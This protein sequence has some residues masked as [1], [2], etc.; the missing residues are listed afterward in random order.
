MPELNAKE[1]AVLEVVRDAIDHGLAPSVR[2]ICARLGMKS[3]STAH[4]YLKS[5]EEKGY[6]EREGS[7][8]RAIR[9]PC[10]NVTRVPLVGT[11]TAGQPILAVESIEAY[12]PVP[13]RGDAK[14]FFALRVR[15][16]S[17]I[18]AAILDG[19]IVIAQ[20]RDTAED[21]DIVVAL[22]D[23]EATVKRFFRE[24]K[25]YRLQP[26]NDA[27]EPI[28]TDHVTILGQVVALIRAF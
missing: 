26:E 14:D 21:G 1:A 9:L 22:I 23:D 13:I 4:H 10:G 16:S 25:R 28:Y 24:K 17:M 19:D 20:R 27:M 11:V 3:T 6:I 7:L 5:L 2:E 8:N 12:L 18:K 15:G